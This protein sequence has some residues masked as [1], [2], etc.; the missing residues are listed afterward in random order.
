MRP[1][2]LRL[3]PLRKI[4]REQRR[5]IHT[6]F[7]V[8]GGFLEMTKVD[9]PDPRRPPTYRFPV[10]PHDLEFAVEWPL[11]GTADWTGVP[12]GKDPW[13]L[14]TEQLLDTGSK[15]TLSCDEWLG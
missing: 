6:G 10:A 12:S 9:E 7:G 5:T 11:P 1:L 15:R 4:P 13:L 14:C 8:G 2:Q 3:Q